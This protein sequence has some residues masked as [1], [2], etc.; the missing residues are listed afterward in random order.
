[1]PVQDAVCLPDA[2]EYS[3]PVL[4]L[5]AGPKGGGRGSRGLLSRLSRRRRRRRTSKYCAVS[6]QIENETCRLSRAARVSLL[7]LFVVFFSLFRVDA[8]S[9]SFFEWTFSYFFFLVFAVFILS[10]GVIFHADAGPCFAVGVVIFV[11]S[12]DAHLFS[13]FFVV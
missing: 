3:G 13:F 4:L 1:M 7:L 11:V 2:S 6:D 12:P 9:V 5:N 8:V 10:L